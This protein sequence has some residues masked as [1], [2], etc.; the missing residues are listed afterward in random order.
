M[1][2]TTELSI[3]ASPIHMRMTS[4]YKGTHTH[5]HTYV[6][7]N[8]GFSSVFKSVHWQYEI[9]PYFPSEWIVGWCRSY[10]LF[11]RHS[12]GYIA[13]FKCVWFFRFTTSHFQYLLHVHVKFMKWR[14]SNWQTSKH[15]TFNIFSSTVQRLLQPKHTLIYRQTVWSF[16]LNESEIWT[17]TTTTLKK[18]KRSKELWHVHMKTK[19]STKHSVHFAKK[20]KMW[21]E[22]ITNE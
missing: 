7:T 15:S 8:E 21:N 13:P 4:V 5:T 16:I 1:H 9:R 19:Q 6:K 2:S 10:C 3:A 14:L 18:K 12:Y 11:I 20:T 17:K 22:K